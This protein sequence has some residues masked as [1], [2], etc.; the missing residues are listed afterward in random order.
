MDLRFG[1][2]VCSPRRGAMIFLGAWFLHR[3]SQWKRRFRQSGPR[4]RVKFSFSMVFK[5]SILFLW[6]EGEKNTRDVFILCPTQ[7]HSSREVLFFWVLRR[8]QLKSTTRWPHSWETD[9]PRLQPKTLFVHGVG[10]TQQALCPFELTLPEF[11]RQTSNKRT[12][13]LS[14][15]RKV[16]LF[17]NLPFSQVVVTCKWFCQTQIEWARFSSISLRA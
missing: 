10:S 13:T 8:G 7:V 17:I 2:S 16:S 4:H 11:C 5:T 12:Q 9:R 15:S 3:K 6:S 14:F 1:W